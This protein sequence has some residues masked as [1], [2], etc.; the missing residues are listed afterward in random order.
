ML[1][2]IDRKCAKQRADKLREGVSKLQIEVRGQ[3]LQGFTVSMG[4]A[5]Y[6]DHAEAAEG[7]L[8]K[9]DRALYV[10]KEQGRNRVCMATTDETVAVDQSRQ[11]NQ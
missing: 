10:A 8:E 11:Q 1:N 7:L 2:E 9:A 4:V 3:L 6:P 5:M